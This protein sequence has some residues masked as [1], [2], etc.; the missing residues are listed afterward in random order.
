MIFECVI[1][2]SVGNDHS[3]LDSLFAS[4]LSQNCLVDVHKDSDHNRSVFTFASKELGVI[5]RDAKALIDESFK[6]FDIAMHEGV[7]PRI[8]I[9]DVLPFVMYD[10]RNGSLDLSNEN[11]FLNDVKCFAE[12]IH[13]DFN[14]PIFFYDFVH[15]DQ[16]RTLPEIRR[17]AFVNFAPNIGANEPHE[18]YGAIAL[19]IRNPLV[20]I[21]VNLH[22]KDLDLAKKL[23]KEIRESNG[24]VKGVRALGLELKSQNMVQ[25]SMNIFDLEQANVG[26]VCVTVRNMAKDFDVESDVELVGLI[27]KFHFEKLSSE[28]LQWSKL[29]ETSTVENHLSQVQPAEE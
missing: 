5:F 20:A 2:V 24:G 4:S 26:D 18:K 6:S 15:E 14:V 9:V 10:E 12:E 17:N 8:G 27:P 7:H 23:S 16:I 13:K 25:V 3:E 29:T 1:N 22:S 11:E 21:N 28:F 19:G